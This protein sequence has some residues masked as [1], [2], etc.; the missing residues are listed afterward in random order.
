MEKKCSKAPTKQEWRVKNQSKLAV[1]LAQNWR[2]HQTTTAIQ[3]MD[4]GIDEKDG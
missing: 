4:I 1:E 3:L 2:F